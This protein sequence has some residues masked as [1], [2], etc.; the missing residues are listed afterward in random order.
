MKVLKKEDKVSNN[1][2]IVDKDIDIDTTEDDIN[3]LRT[4]KI[5]KLINGKEIS[6]KVKASLW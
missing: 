3:T 1:K 4:R 2:N 5:A 6:A